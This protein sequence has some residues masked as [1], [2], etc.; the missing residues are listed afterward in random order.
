PVAYSQGFHPSPRLSFGPPLNVG[1]GGLREYFDMELRAGCRIM[2][3]REDLNQEL[4]DGLRINEAVFVP[5]SEPS[6][7][8][9]ITRYE[10]E[11]ICPDASVTDYFLGL[12]SSIITRQKSSGNY[13]TVDLR[14]MVEEATVID[15]HT[16]K[17]VVRDT[18]EDKVRLGELVPV[19]FKAP[20]EEFLITRTSLFGWK[21]GWVEPLI[22]QDAGCGTL[23]ARCTM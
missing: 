4:P 3:L 2:N 19:M 6:L 17:L 15:D 7:Q 5:E 21:N 20:A 9:F 22:I 16:V 1:V 12:K 18:G 23:D 14:P 13:T 8:R 10:Y 11:I